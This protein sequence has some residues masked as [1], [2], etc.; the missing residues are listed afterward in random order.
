MEG[1]MKSEELYK[2]HRMV[3]ESYFL[4]GEDV[5]QYLRLVENKYNRLQSMHALLAQESLG[6]GNERSRLAD[7]QLEISNWFDGQ[8][9]V[10][11]Q[12]FY[13]CLSLKEIGL[14]DA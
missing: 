11:R 10:S 2:F 9:E 8:L 5:I 13:K 14:L 3:S 12:V 4:F 6:L 7:E 1:Q